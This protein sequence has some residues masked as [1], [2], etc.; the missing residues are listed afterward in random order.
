[1]TASVADKGRGRCP[2]KFESSILTPKAKP[3]R[4]VIE[5]GPP[6][7]E[8]PLVER[9]E[10]FR[11]Q[12]DEYRTAIVTEPRGSDVLVGALVCPPSDPDCH[13]GVIFFNNIGYLGMCGHGMIGLIESLKHCGRIR[14]ACCRIETPVGIVSAEVNDDDTVSVSNVESYRVA[15]DVK[16]D[17]DG[18][19]TV[20]G[21]VAWGGNWFFIVREPRHDLRVEMTEELGDMA[22]SIRSAVHD[23]GHPK[24]D[25]VMLFGESDRPDVDSR[26]FVLCP[27]G[28]FDRSPCGTGTSAKLACLAADGKLQPGDTWVQEGIMGTAFTGRYCWADRDRGRILPTITGRAYVTGEATLRL[29]DDDPFAWGLRGGVS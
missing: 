6:L 9:L 10:L 12:F 11:N 28:G 19:G 13:T 7:G 23:A 25:H 21:D 16:I 4:V 18:V 20:V 3:T 29:H 5:G 8:G 14:T 24:V 22:G 17:A 2:K 27:G 26:N 15:S 1:M